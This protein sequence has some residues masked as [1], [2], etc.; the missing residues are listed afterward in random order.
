M[1]KMLPKGGSRG[2]LRQPAGSLMNL[3]DGFAA[4]DQRYRIYQRL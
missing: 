4:L 3:N 1:D 2:L